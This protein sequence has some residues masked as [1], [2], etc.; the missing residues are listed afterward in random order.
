MEDLI[1]VVLVNIEYR[2]QSYATHYLCYLS[3]IIMF[4]HKHFKYT[5]VHVKEHEQT[6]TE[7]YPYSSCKA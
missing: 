6:S 7:Q 1:F 3:D 4:I 2:F 5:H